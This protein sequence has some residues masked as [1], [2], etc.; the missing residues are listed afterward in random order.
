MHSASTTSSVLMNNSEHDA[1]LAH[2]D[3]HFGEN[4]VIDHKMLEEFLA[5]SEDGKN[6]TV[7]SIGKW[8]RHQQ[9]KSRANNPEYNLT[10]KLETGA[11]FEASTLL[12]VFG[13]D[14][15]VPVDWIRTWYGLH[16]L[17]SV[18]KN[19]LKDSSRAGKKTL[20]GCS[21]RAS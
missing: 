15:K 1:S 18:T 14:G 8:R 11:Y 19:S 6:L 3:T 4:W 20:L 21:K 13:K 16:Y 10:F 7:N 12:T 9:D 2:K 5:T 17:G